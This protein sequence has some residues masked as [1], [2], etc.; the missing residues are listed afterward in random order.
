M[1]PKMLLQPLAENA[2]LH[3]LSGVSAGQ[4]LVT[5]RETDEKLL[6]IR[7][8]DNGCGLP[9]ELLG[10]YRPPEQPTGHL[11]LLNVDTILRKHY[12]ERFGLRLENNT[13][14][15]GA[16]IIAVLPAGRRDSQC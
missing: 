2:I 15:G 6:E 12:G 7:V 5:A 11:G 14:G 9:P 13:A 4:L 10:P 16:C 1:V 8:C 3:G